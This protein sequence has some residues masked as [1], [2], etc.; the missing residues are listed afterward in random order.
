MLS[1]GQML[2][3]AVSD[4]YGI[5][6]PILLLVVVELSKLART[7][8]LEQAVEEK[9]Y[10]LILD[11]LASPFAGIIRIFRLVLRV[12]FRRVFP[13]D[14]ENVTIPSNLEQKIPIKFLY[15]RLGSFTVIHTANVL[16]L[17]SGIYITRSTISDFGVASGPVLFVL[18]LFLLPIFEVSEY[19]LIAA[20]NKDNSSLFLYM[21]INLYFYYLAFGE[22]DSEHLL[23]NPG[24]DIILVYIGWFVTTTYVYLV[25]LARDIRSAK[26]NKTTRDYWGI[27]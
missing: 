8:D 15:P 5:L 23:L 9:H 12:L 17:V 11:A 7:I 22:S 14:R 10:P 1:D 25:F 13:W 3:S 16:V 21:Y 20:N 6:A 4:S 2:Q 18:G 24:T 27:E 26:S 19:D